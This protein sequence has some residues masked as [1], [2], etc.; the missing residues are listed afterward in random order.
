METGGGKDP[1][2]LP[3]RVTPAP[4]VPA[5]A[6]AAPGT[7]LALKQLP[8]ASTSLR[9]FLYEFCVGLSLGAHPAVVA[10]YGIA[11]ESADSYS[12]L[13]EPVLHGDL[14]TLIQ[15]KVGCAEP[16]RVPRGLPRS[17]GNAPER[18]GF[19]KRAHCLGSQQAFPLPTPLAGS[20]LGFAQA[21]SPHYDPWIRW[22]RQP[23]WGRTSP[24]QTSRDSTGPH[25]GS[26]G[27]PIRRTP[28]SWACS[29]GAGQ[30]P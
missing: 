14:I 13:T 1:C 12:F 16:R 7:P 29:R 28:G 9:G 8:K 4:A 2:W 25:Q 23:S 21:T 10:A 11:I 19:S 18:P 26:A 6:P 5:P 17:L 30:R 27:Q 20:P 24:H 3:S 22:I 15:P